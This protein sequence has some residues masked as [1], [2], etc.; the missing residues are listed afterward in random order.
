MTTKLAIFFQ[1]HVLDLTVLIARALK[2]PEAELSENNNAKEVLKAHKVFFSHFQLQDKSRN[3][4]KQ[5]CLSRNGN[6]SNPG[7]YQIGSKIFYK[8]S[9]LYFD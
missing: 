2:C 4:K 5:H 3:K 6:R 9:N 7:H 8:T 1:P